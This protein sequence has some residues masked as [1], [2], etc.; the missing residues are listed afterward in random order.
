MTP[1]DFEKLFEKVKKNPEMIG[2]S[3]SLP[4]LKGLITYLAG[5]PSM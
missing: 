2:S 4:M 1:G 5:Y 3:L